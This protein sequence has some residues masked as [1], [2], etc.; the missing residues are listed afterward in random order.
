MKSRRVVIT[1]VGAIA[2]G[3]T[4]AK[5]LWRRVTQGPAA[6][7]TIHRFD[8]SEYQSQI[9]AE[10]TVFDG[11]IYGLTPEQCQVLDRSSQFALAATM[12]AVADADVDEC[13]RRDPERVGACMGTAIGG[14]EMM[15]YGFASAFVPDITLNQRGQELMPQDGSFP[16][17]MFRSF[18]PNTITT[19]IMAH[20]GLGGPC[21]TVSTGCTASADAI[22]YAYTMIERGESDIMICGG[23]DAPLTPIT[24]AAFD[25]IKAVTRRN[26][27]PTQASRPFDRDRDGFLLAEGCGV[28]VLE[29]LEHAQSR[30]APIY[31]ELCGFGTSCNAYHMTG[32]P[33]D[34]EALARAMELALDDASVGRER[35]GYINAHGSSTPQNDVNETNAIKR[36]F[37]ERAYQIPVSGTKSAIGHPLGAA[38]ALECIV[39]ALA[40]KH[41]FLPPT[42]NYQTPDP[43]CDLDYLPNQGR[44]ARIDIALSNSSGFSGL[45]SVLVLGR[46]S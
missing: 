29:D 16:S 19:E 36:V 31:A 5:Q 2:S 35:V 43:A 46:V 12:L 8:V 45:H 9:A 24:L 3:A 13:I 22:G 20:F 10:V 17:T 15:D 34:G 14:I 44:S 38:G 39:T 21:T 40:I 4:G 41:E 1:G 28:L 30:H 11:V 26:N 25:V 23:S 18:M 7:A 32:L 37:G 42:L 33:E 27:T 6:G